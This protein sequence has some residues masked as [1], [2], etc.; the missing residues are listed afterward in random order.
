MATAPG[1]SNYYEHTWTY[2]QSESLP[3]V[4]RSRRPGAPACRIASAAVAIDV[5]Q[6]KPLLE[7]QKP[8]S[9]IGEF[10][11]YKP[12]HE[13]DAAEHRKA[14]TRSAI[15]RVSWSPIDLPDARA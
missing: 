15:H 1:Y 13:K 5:A 14:C 4:R 7:P 3:R 10:S 12:I 2:L 8:A 11:D 6:P 9:E